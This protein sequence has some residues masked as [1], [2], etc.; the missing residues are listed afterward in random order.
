[1]RIVWQKVVRGNLEDTEA[2]N[3][4]EVEPEQREAPRIL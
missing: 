4:L 3:L 2:E 1:M